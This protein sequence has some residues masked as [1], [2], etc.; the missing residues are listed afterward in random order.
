[1]RIV[2]TD[3][4][5]PAVS[6]AKESP[7]QPVE[8]T[9]KNSKPRRSTGNKQGNSCLKFLLAIIAMLA[10]IGACLYYLVMYIG[11][12]MVK[13]IDAVPADFPKNLPLYALD[14]AKIKVQTPENKQQLAKLINSLPDWSLAPFMG[15]LTTDL[16]TQV[17]ASKKD[18]NLPANISAKDLAMALNQGAGQTK[19]V[20][21]EWDNIAKKKIDLFDYYKKQLQTAGFTVNEQ[22]LD[23]EIDLSFFKP[24]ID[25]AMSIAD[26]F[27]KDNNSVMKMTINYLSK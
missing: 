25:G 1:M 16:K 14:Q 15:Y 4:P 13:A 8:N 3:R 6:Q 2:D 12:P 7:V 11:G 9:A 22:S 20:G 5:M 26:S 27:M 23:N 10:I 19:T 18:F 21:L 24:G 17:A